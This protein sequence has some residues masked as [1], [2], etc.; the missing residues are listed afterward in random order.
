MLTH[1]NVNSSA[2]PIFVLDVLVLLLSLNQ[3]NTMRCTPLAIIFRVMALC[4]ITDILVKMP[5]QF[6]W[7]WMVSCNIIHARSVCKKNLI[8][9]TFQ[10]IFYL[11]V[12]LYQKPI[13]FLDIPVHSKIAVFILQYYF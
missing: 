10:L 4:V 6:L 9:A 8:D 13:E 12:T 7:S 5:L 11:F 1:A 2:V 3:N